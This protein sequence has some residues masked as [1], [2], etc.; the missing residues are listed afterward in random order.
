M[1]ERE[2]LKQTAIKAARL[3]GAILLD[4][5]RGGF[6]V[7]HKDA[8]NLVTDA[9]RRAEQAVVDVIKKAYPTHHI[10]AEE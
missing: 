7:E 10:L 4:Y 5:A 1:D 8:V 3:A 2:A 9:D 6:R